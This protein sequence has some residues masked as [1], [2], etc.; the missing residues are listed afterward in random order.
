[1]RFFSVGLTFHLKERKNCKILLSVRSRFKGGGGEGSHV[2][3]LHRT[4]Q[5]LDIFPKLRHFFLD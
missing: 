3:H 4:F 5:C 2:I 1:M